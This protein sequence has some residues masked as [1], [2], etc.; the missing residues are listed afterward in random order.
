MVSLEAAAAWQVVVEEPKEDREAVEPTLLPA[1]AVRA[2]ILPKAVTCC[3]E[4]RPSKQTAVVTK[5]RQRIIVSR[6]K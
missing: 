4:D 6:R 2:R 1:V 5:L 3:T